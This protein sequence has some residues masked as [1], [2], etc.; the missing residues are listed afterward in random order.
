MANILI[1]NPFLFLVAIPLGLALHFIIN[2][3]SYQKGG[4]TL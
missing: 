1:S 3:R 4:K 2:G